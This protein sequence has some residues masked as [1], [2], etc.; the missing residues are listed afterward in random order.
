MKLTNHLLTTDH[1][2]SWGSDDSQSCSEPN[3]VPIRKEEGEKADE[4]K[5]EYED[6]PM[7]SFLKHT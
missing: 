3:D 4:G 7:V 2:N 1:F 6:S 5:G